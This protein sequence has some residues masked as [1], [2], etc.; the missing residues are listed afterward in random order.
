MNCYSLWK[1]IDPESH[2]KQKREKIFKD[3][4]NLNSIIS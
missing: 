3:R 2:L 1:L 4:Y